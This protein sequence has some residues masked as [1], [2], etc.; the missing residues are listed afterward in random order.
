MKTWFDHDQLIT[1]KDKDKD[2]IS[3]KQMGAILTIFW[4]YT[5]KCSHSHYFKYLKQMPL[6][7]L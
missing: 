6:Q 1:D 2:I 3:Y 4:E 7:E 5:Y